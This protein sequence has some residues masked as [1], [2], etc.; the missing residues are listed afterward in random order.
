M[1]TRTAGIFGRTVKRDHYGSTP[2]TVAALLVREHGLREGF[3]RLQVRFAPKGA[4]VMMEM[5]DGTT[6]AVPAMIVGA[7][8]FGIQQWFPLTEGEAPDDLTVDARE[9][10]PHPTIIVPVGGPQAN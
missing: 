3:W 8:E 6:M 4:N 2:K 10:N 5:P 1:G 9:V 7:Y